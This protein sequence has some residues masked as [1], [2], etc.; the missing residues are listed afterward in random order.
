MGDEMSNEQELMQRHALTCLYQA[1]EQYFGP[2]RHGGE[3]WPTYFDTWMR[4]ARQT[5]DMQSA[6]TPAANA[7]GLL[8]VA[9]LL[10]LVDDLVLTWVEDAMPPTERVAARK[11][12]EDAIRAF[13]SRPT[14]TS[15]AATPAQDALIAELDWCI[16]EGNTGPRSHAALKMAR[17]ALSQQDSKDAAWVSVEDRLPEEGHYLVSAM[18]DE[19]PFVTEMYF[20][21]RGHWEYQSQPTYEYTFYV[22]VTHWKLLPAPAALRQQSDKR[23]G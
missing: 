2:S 1:I 10:Q 16:A 22:G 18:S 17:A 5:L 19:G 9:E 3:T 4:Q 11:V 13:A 15:A 8:E 12:L 6:V 21:E 14:A 20:T 7:G 23:E